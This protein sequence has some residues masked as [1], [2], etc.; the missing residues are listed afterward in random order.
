MLELYLMALIGTLKMVD[1]SYFDTDRVQEKK[2]SSS[3]NFLWKVLVFWL[4]FK[5]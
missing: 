5:I 4:K 1:A 3:Q 2:N